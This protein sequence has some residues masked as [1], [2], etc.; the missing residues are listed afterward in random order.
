MLWFCVAGI[1]YDSIPNYYEGLGED[2]VIEDIESYEPD[3]IDNESEQSDQVAAGDTDVAG[4]ET[5]EEGS[6]VLFWV[7]VGVF[8]LGIFFI[9]KTLI[10]L[11]T[12]PFKK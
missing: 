10:K 11:I 2:E 9:V 4:E 3:L 7:I 5:S 12:K 1:D 8:L 6:S